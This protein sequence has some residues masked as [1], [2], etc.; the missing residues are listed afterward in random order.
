LIS[1]NALRFAAACARCLHGAYS[2]DTAPNPSGS[3]A[4]D[5]DQQPGFPIRLAAWL[6]TSEGVRLATGKVVY[7]L[8]FDFWLKIFALSFAMGLVSGI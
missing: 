2:H 3:A 8:V 6:A 7:R 5:L 4:I 1:V